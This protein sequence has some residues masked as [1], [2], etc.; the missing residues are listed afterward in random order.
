MFLDI[1]S[2]IPQATNSLGSI[3]SE[4]PLDQIL[5]LAVEMWREIDLTEQNLLVD[6]EWIFIKEGRI[7][8]GGGGGHLTVIC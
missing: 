6:T 1:I 8:A 3:S 7:A 4:E 5:R 2:P